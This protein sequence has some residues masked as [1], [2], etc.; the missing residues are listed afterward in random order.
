MARAVPTADTFTLV[1]GQTLFFSWSYDL[2]GRTA[3][4]HV[5]SVSGLG[6]PTALPEATE[7]ITPEL[8]CTITWLLP[9]FGLTVVRTAA[10]GEQVPADWGAF[11]CNIANRFLLQ[12]RG[13]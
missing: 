1:T 8:A 12:L 9:T 3:L 5:L 11:S 6:I 4:H 7:F 2:L 13:L 10:A